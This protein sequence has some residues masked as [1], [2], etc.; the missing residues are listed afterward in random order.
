MPA[1]IFVDTGGWIAISDTAD[2]YHA[3]ASAFYR[4]ISRERR[5]LVSTNLVVAETYRLVLYTAGYRSAIRFLAAIER[6]VEVDRLR[7][8]YSSPDVEVDA[9]QILRQYDD[10]TF[11]YTDAVSFAVMRALGLAD[12]FAFDKHF[13]TMGFV[14]LPA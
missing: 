12:A 14:C 9:R 10:Q 1:D 7:L 11:S 4:R 5:R 8:V 13:S 2:H 3:P 6:G